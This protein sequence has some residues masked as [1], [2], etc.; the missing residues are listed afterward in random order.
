MSEQ[1]ENEEARDLRG[2]FPSGTRLKVQLKNAKLYTEQD[3]SRFKI[4]KAYVVN[5]SPGRAFLINAI[6]LNPMSAV[7]MGMG[8][9]ATETDFIPYT[10]N[11]CE[12]G[13]EF[14]F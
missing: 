2:L 14:F 12:L 6:A 11:L 1:H 8:F 5:N 10:I 3:T 13:K 4:G 9:L 7:P